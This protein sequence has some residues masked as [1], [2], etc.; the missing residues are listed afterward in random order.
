MPDPILGLLSFV[1]LLAYGAIGG[2]VGSA[3]VRILGTKDA[4]TSFRGYGSHRHLRAIA[5]LNGAD[6]EA[7]VGF[8]CAAVFWPVTVA[9]GFVGAL[10]YGPYWLALKC[11]QYSANALMPATATEAQVDAS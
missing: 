4:D 1:G 7:W 6:D 10:C 11:G 2:V 9:L 5:G 8:S 3:A